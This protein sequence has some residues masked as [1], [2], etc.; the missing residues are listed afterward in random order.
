MRCSPCP[1]ILPRGRRSAETMEI[2]AA[3]AEQPFAGRVPEWKQRLSAQREQLKQR[4]L[5]REAPGD[6]LRHLCALVD[7][8]L[9]E[10]WTSFGIPRELALLAVGGYGRGELFP[11]SDV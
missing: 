11:Y 1:R 3:F 5:L 7:R 9:R 6:L 10:V 4:F 8:Q 2:Q